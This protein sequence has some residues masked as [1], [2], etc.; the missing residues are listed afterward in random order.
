MEIEV[1]DKKVCKNCGKLKRLTS[2]FK[3][4]TGRDGFS[5]ICK[6]CIKNKTKTPKKSKIK[7]KLND[8]YESQ[9]EY[10]LKNTFGISLEEY[11]D[12]YTK[13]R[14]CCWICE[15][16]QLESGKTLHIDHNH[17][18]GKIRGL[19][20]SNHN[21]GLG[22]FNDNIELLENAIEYLKIHNEKE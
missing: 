14:G 15:I 12:L 17:K 7:K 5:K 11:N 3:T 2:F 19:L 8:K 6:V 10:Y 22:M 13:Q 20:C 18:T 1:L 9:R 4:P 16:S 21:T